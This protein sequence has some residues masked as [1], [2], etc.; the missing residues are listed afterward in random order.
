MRKISILFLRLSILAAALLIVLLGSYG[1]YSLILNPVNPVYAWMLYPIIAGVYVSLLPLFYGFIQFYKLLGLAEGKTGAESK[2][3]ILKKLRKGSL[4]FGSM[5]LLT[6]PF[7]F[8]VAQ[9]DDAPG[10]ILFYL[11]PFFFALVL[12]AI[13][14]L[15][16]DQEEAGK[17]E[18]S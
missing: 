3:V 1:L 7:V 10:L 6:E 11:I 8:Q 5:Y 14:T 16:M 4:V 12:G 2:N 15:F 13:V 17:K 18:A 9:E